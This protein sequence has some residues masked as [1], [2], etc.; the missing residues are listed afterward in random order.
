MERKWFSMA[1]MIEASVE[2]LISSSQKNDEKLSTISRKTLLQF[3]MVNGSIPRTSPG[4]VPRMVC[5][6]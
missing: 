4:A 3:G 1:A 2:F 6:G 5:K